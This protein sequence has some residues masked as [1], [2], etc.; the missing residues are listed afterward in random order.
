[1]N[2]IPKAFWNV[3]IATIGLLAL[4]L[5]A[6][7]VAEFKSIE[8]VGANPNQTDT[9]TVSGTGDALA[10]P[11][12]ATFSFSVT[13]TAKT[14]ADAQSAATAK[15]DKALTAVRAGGVADKD[16]STQSYTIQPHYEYQ[17]T[18]CATGIYCPPGK[19]VLTGYDVS[20]T[21]QV[22]VR[23]LSSAGSLFSS[24]GSAGV[25][26]VN[27]LDFTI[28]DPT[29]VQA[30]ARAKAIADA[31]TKAQELAKELGVSL[32]GVTSFYENNGP[33][34]IYGMGVKAMAASTGAV[35]PS[36]QVPV[37]DQKVTDMVSITYQIR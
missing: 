27:G 21:I 34:P 3:S 5:L 29:A 19:Q 32:A 17:S 31:Q 4:F 8:Y 6:A 26:Q 35:A 2:N 36:P 12:V 18:A 9:I 37:G 14:V 22:K 10:T 13:E 33:E 28:D 1:M 11:D 24:I 20:E 16:I 25:Q 7:A 23:D 30:Q 15:I